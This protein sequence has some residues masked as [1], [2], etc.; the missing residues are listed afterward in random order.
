[1]STS[2]LPYRGVFL[3]PDAHHFGTLVA[4]TVKEDRYDLSDIVDEIQ[5]A[6]QTERD[7]EILAAAWRNERGFTSSVI[8]MAMIPT[9]QHI[10][11]MGPAA[12]RW[13]LADLKQTHDHWFWALKSIARFDPVPPR[14]RG[15]VAAMTK[16]WIEWGEKRGLC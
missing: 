1:M 5:D 13:I 6:D 9:Y 11:G 3:I 14:D 8:E 12:L 16:A 4:D 2:T 10:I 15:N 7:F